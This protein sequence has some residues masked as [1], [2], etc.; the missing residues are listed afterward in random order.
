MVSD[1][2]LFGDLRAKV[3][4]IADSKRQGYLGFAEFVTA[5]QVRPLTSIS[6]SVC[7]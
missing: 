7:I 2:S 5:M 1:I 6:D 4:A 3:W